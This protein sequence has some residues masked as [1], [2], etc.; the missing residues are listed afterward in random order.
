MILYVQSVRVQPEDGW[1]DGVI[2]RAYTV[3]LYLCSLS[4]RSLTGDRGDGSA[5]L[6]L[7]VAAVLMA[8]AAWARDTFDADG[9]A[10]PSHSVAALISSEGEMG[11]CRPER[12]P[13]YGD[14]GVAG[15]QLA[16]L[17]PLPVD[18]AAE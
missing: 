6:S 18:E 16:K 8:I 2:A 11:V 13:G 5:K 9:V 4:S 7:L 12:W 3:K 1:T 14:A 15:D 10:A 17:R